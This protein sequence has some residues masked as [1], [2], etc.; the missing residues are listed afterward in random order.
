[1]LRGVK[2]MVQRDRSAS[3]LVL[4]ENALYR[5]EQRRDVL[6]HY[7]NEDLSGNAVVGMD[8]DIPDIR[9]M[10][11]HG[12]SAWAKRYASS[13]LRAASP[14]ISRLRQTASWTTGTLGHVVSTPPV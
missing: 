4:A 9:V 1:M 13:N 7:I 5:G 6:P 8:Q 3:V 11:R 10:A 14:M 12:I 2:K